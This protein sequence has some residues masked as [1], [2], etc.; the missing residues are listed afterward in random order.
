VAL[1]MAAEGKLH[2]LN[3]ERLVSTEEIDNALSDLKH[4]TYGGI[5]GN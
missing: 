4:L 5:V 1:E 3:E 2:H